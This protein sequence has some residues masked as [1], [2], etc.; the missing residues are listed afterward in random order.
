M[1]KSTYIRIVWT[2][3]S[4]ASLA[5]SLL[6]TWCLWCTFTL[7]LHW[8]VEHDTV[9]IESRGTTFKLERDIR[10]TNGLLS[11]SRC[12]SRVECAVWCAT[13]ESCSH[14]NY[15]AGQ[16]ELLSAEPSSRSMETGWSHGYNL[17]N[18]KA[19]TCLKL[20]VLS[21]NART[22]GIKHTWFINIKFVTIFIPTDS[23]TG[24]HYTV[25][26]KFSVKVSAPLTEHNNTTIGIISSFFVYHPCAVTLWY[27][28]RTVDEVLGFDLNQILSQSHCSDWWLLKVKI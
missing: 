11:A 12:D 20:H 9:S 25:G 7:D 2:E 3:L 14:F 15:G 18:G 24:I 27:M 1:V 10:Y 16:C 21:V 22:G 26:F 23:Y 19:L 5:W 13:L 17:E 28:G 8:S 6:T 4:M